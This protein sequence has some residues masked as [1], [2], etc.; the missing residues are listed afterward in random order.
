MTS[1]GPA[2]LPLLPMPEIPVRLLPVLA[3]G[4]ALRAGTMVPGA[5]AEDSTSSA[6]SG[7]GPARARS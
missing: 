7:D 6:P 5:A 4:V 2:G 1:S 3:T